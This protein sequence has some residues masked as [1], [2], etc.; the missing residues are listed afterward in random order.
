MSFDFMKNILHWE[1]EERFARLCESLEEVIQ[2]AR[3]EAGDNKISD[4]EL[5][6]ALDFVGVNLCRD[7]WEEFKKMD[8][9]RD[10][11]SSSGSNPKEK[12]F[13]H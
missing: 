11:G 5:M 3:A 7:G 4:L 10:L 2:E 12:N 1:D 8:F 6:Q 9:N 13:L